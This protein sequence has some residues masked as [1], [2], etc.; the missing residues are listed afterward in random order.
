LLPAGTPLLPGDLVFFGG[1]PAGVTHVGLVVGPGEM[2][3]APHAGAAVRVEPFPAE[4]G[5]AWGG[6]VVV[7]FSRPS[8]LDAAA[9]PGTSA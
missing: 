2:V 3:D 1:G 5:S 6:D 4:P 8:A 9:S 7:G